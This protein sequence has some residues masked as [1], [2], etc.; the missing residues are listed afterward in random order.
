MNPK[1]MSQRG[2]AHARNVLTMVMP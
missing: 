2:T 1:S